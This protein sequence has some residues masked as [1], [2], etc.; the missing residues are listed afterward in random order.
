MKKFTFLKQFAAFICLFCVVNLG[1]GQIVAWEM[2]GKP[3][4]DITVN[5]TT[6]AA[7]L[8]TSTLSRGSGLGPDA[9]GNAFSSLSFTGSG[10][11]PT[12]LT[13]ADYLQFQISAISGYQ[14][15]LSTLDATFR[16][17]NAGPSSFIWKYSTN[18]ITFTDIGTTISYDTNGGNGTAQTQINLTTISALQNVASGT[19]I[20]IRLYGWGA[21]SGTGTFAI[22]RQPGN[23]LSVGGT[24]TLIPQCPTSTTFKSLS[25]WSNADGNSLTKEVI[26]EAD[27][28]TSTANIKA[29]T[30]IVRS[31]AILTVSDFTY[32]EVQ[33]DIIVEAGGEINVQPYGAIVQ[34]DDLGIVT[35]NGA[36]SV[37]KKTAPANAWYEYTYWSSPVKNA[38]IHNGLTESNIYRRYSFNAQNFLDATME[39]GN[40]NGIVAGQD[41]IDDDGNDWKGLSGNTIMLPGVGYAATHD[42]LVF[43]FSLGNQID[44]TFEGEFNNG[45]IEVPVYRND[46]SVLDKNWNFIGNPYPSA[47][48]ASAFFTQNI[49]DSTTNPTG[50]MEGA[51]YYWSQSTAPSTSSNGNATYNFSSS[52]YAMYNGTG[53]SAGGDQLTPNEF[54]PSGQGFFISFSQSRPAST[55]NVVF[56][57][58]MRVKEINDNGQFFKNTGSKN[59]NTANSNK[60]WVNL[61]S[62]NGVFNQ[63]LIGYINGA[64]NDDDGSFYDAPK[65]PLVSSAILYST[66]EGSTKKFAIQ[67]KDANSLDENETIKLGFKTSINVATLYKLSIEQLEGNFLN[68]NQV[69]LKD[70]LLNKVHNLST[71]D[72]TFTS[73]VGEFNSR[74]E[75]TFG[76][77]ILAIEDVLLSKNALRIVELEDSYMQFNTSSNLT[78]KNVSIFDLLGRQLYSFKGTSASETYQLSNLSNSVFIAKVTLSNGAVIT[79]KATKK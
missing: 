9:L 64:T 59:K 38:D 72:Y 32:I 70:L 29:C 54:I 39:S 33:N 52:D 48:S 77:K 49:Y 57:N 25:G 8:N 31:G 61:T 78:I 50:T 27:Y 53:G 13:N 15:S 26:I 56:N 40:N 22:G 24:V 12:A 10:T 17:T 62:D 1:F 67:G 71:S 43:S 20:T 47:I 11:Q 65:R 14:V 79:K 75:I 45:I 6:L 3:G 63:I 23:D 44:Y 55:G 73:S 42:P 19:T 28:E 7:N 18:G 69:Y 34:I 5:A 16:K 2:E 74:F 68:S 30:L 51:I 35:N 60:L 36:M 76:N 66:I 21:S 4:N 46:G 37:T 41:D 58:A